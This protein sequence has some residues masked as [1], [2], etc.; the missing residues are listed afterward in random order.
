MYIPVTRALVKKFAIGICYIGLIILAFSLVFAGLLN[1]DPAFKSP[2]T[3][4]VKTLS[5]MMGDLAYDSSFVND[6]FPL[7]YPIESNIL[8]VLYVTTIAGFI[9]YVISNTSSDLNSKTVHDSEAQFLN[10]SLLSQ[11]YYEEVM[12]ATLGLYEPVYIS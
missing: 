5:W 1:H 10:V 9:V 11:L 12:L 4:F 6:E 3:S 8:F 2:I 7:D